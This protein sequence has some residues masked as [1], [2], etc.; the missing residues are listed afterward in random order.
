[1]TTENEQRGRSNR[2]AGKRAMARAL[3]FVRAHGA[4]NA[5][6][7]TR[8]H[9][10]DLT[11]IGD[12]AVEVTLEPWQQIAKKADQAAQDAARRGLTDWVIWKPRQSVGDFGRAWAVTEVRQYWAMTQEL[13][14]AR[15]ELAILRDVIGSSVKA[16]GR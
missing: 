12:L 3:E 2:R 5:D 1:M 16:A 7:V 15:A 11:G 4:P 14:K 10:S 13:E 8:Y 6:V 9:A